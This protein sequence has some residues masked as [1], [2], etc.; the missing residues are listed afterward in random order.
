MKLRFCLDRRCGN[1]IR[2]SPRNYSSHHDLQNLHH[3]VKSRM[4]TPHL[5]IIEDDLMC[6]HITPYYSTQIPPCASRS[7]YH[8]RNR[9]RTIPAPFGHGSDHR[10]GDGPGQPGQSADA[11]LAVSAAGC[12]SPERRSREPT[13]KFRNEGSHEL[14][15][16]DSNDVSKGAR[17]EGMCCD[18]R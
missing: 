6:R 4:T 10:C 5:L 15:G 2:L 12:G 14:P 1:N 16:S 17:F 7:P 18:E 9:V 3:V 13:E 11:R 8:V